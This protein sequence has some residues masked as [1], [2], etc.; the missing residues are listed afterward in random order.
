[1]PSVLIFPNDRVGALSGGASSTEDLIQVN[2]RRILLI[3]L[4]AV[5]SKVV[6]LPNQLKKGI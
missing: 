2:S 1:M 6:F 5:F 4:T 3:D